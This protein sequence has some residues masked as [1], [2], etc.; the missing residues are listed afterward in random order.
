[1]G[2]AS[3]WARSAR[4]PGEV[5]PRMLPPREEDHDPLPLPCSRHDAGGEQ[6]VF[7]TLLLLPPPAEG[8][9][10]PARISSCWCHRYKRPRLALLLPTTTPAWFDLCVGRLR[11]PFEPHV[12]ATGFQGRG[13][14]SRSGTLAETLRR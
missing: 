10:A 11:C 12:V 1:M 14:G 6:P 13:I 5:L 4:H 2:G 3:P 7:S 8:S 9:P